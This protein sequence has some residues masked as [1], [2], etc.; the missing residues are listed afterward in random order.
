M[1]SKSEKFT[2]MVFT[3]DDNIGVVS[4]TECFERWIEKSDSDPKINL[5]EVFGMTWDELKSNYKLGRGPMH[6]KR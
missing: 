3:N 4:F 5:L 6:S 2:P 1:D